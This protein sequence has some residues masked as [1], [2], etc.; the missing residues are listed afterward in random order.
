MWNT[1]F[2]LALSS[3]QQT[4]QPAQQKGHQDDKGAEAPGVRQGRTV[5]TE[6]RKGDTIAVYKYLMAGNRED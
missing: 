2:S 4:L 6:Q 3:T 1:A 5:C